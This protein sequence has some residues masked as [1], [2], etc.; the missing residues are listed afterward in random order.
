MSGRSPNATSGD[1][2]IA[3]VL[4][5]VDDTLFD[6]S[7]AERLAALEHLASQGLL[8][9]YGSEEEAAAH[10]HEVSEAFVRRYLDGALTFQDQRRE[11]ARALAGRAFTDDEADAW[12]GGYLGAYQHHW[13][14]FPD[15]VPAL[16]ALA[17]GYRHGV[18]SNHAACAALDLPPEA[19][20]YVGDLADNDARAADAAGL[21]GIWLD[22]NGTEPGPD[23]PMRI[24]SL[25]ELPALLAEPHR[26][27]RAAESPLFDRS[28]IVETEY[29]GGHAQPT[30]NLEPR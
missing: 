20:A 12:F 11:R 2:Q 23:G 15:A 30:S 16:D 27:G 10:W 1:R 14:A 21:T 13:R 7:G 26:Y 8:E 18:L 22:R 29:W 5:D 24:T 4:W 28:G 17:A 6:H 9:R 3:A 19:V 25:A